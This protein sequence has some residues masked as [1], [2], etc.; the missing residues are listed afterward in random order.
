MLC[1][2][3]H[4]WGELTGCVGRRLGAGVLCELLH[5]WGELNGCVG[6]DGGGAS[7]GWYVV[8]TTT[9]LGRTEWVCGGGMGGGASGGWCVV[10][11][12]IQLGRTDWVRLGKGG[13]G[14][15]CGI[16]K[17]RLLKKENYFI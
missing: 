15:V 10:R 9:H 17:K 7:V 5:N 11:T 6:G 14:G 2:L 1:E 13:G 12:T 8:Q 16:K 3:L 4:N